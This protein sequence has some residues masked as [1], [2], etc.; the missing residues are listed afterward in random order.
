MCWR[1][2]LDWY[3]RYCKTGQPNSREPSGRS[4]ENGKLQIWNAHEEE[5]YCGRYE[6]V[7]LFKTRDEE[8]MKN[9]PNLMDFRLGDYCLENY[10]SEET[11]PRGCYKAGKV[12][13]FVLLGKMWT[14]GFLMPQRS[15]GG[16]RRQAVLGRE[17]RRQHVFLPQEQPP[18]FQGG[19][20][21][22]RTRFGERS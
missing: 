13:N 14:W 11:S 17:D 8:D 10:P 12:Q 1:G 2:N 21:S 5:P 22:R 4:N 20:E 18:Y 7:I 9:A 6:A 19:V 16:G 15:A 3:P